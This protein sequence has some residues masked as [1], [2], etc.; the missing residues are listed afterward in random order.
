MTLLNSLRYI[1]LRIQTSKNLKYLGYHLNGTTINF[2]YID[3]INKSDIHFNPC[4]YRRIPLYDF[5]NINVL[6][7]EW[8]PK[9]RSL[10]H[11]HHDKGCISIL[12]KNQLSEDVYCNSTHKF[13]YTNILKIHEVNFVDNDKINHSVYNS[14]DNINSISLHIYPK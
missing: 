11:D 8:N 12:L 4:G 1:N 9:S 3:I 5:D 7:L 2:K 13:L 10:I 14:C 6:L